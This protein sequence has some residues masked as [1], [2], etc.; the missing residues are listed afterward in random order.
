MLLYGKRVLSLSSGTRV[1][2]F[3]ILS[4]IGSGGMGEVYRARDTRLNRDVALKILP[5]AVAVDPHRL[6]RF[7]RE[8]QVLAALNH[9]HIAA[10]YGFEEG[11]GIDALVMELVGGP[12]LADRIERGPIPIEDALPI[13]RQL[14]EALDAAHEQ[15]IIHRDLKPENIKLTPDGTV[16]VLDF[17]LAKA[18][19]RTSVLSELAQSPT[20]MTPVSTVEGVICGTVAYMSPEQARGRPVDKRTDIW[21]FGCVLFEMLAGRKPF[22]GGSLPDTVA[23]ILTSEPDWRVLPPET[24]PRVRLLIE[25][26]FRKDPTQRLRDIGDVWFQ[27]EDTPNDFLSTDAARQRTRTRR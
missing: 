8:A 4:L 1:G 12:T 22:P 3:Q 23:A 17:G 6:A 25:R 14:A 16:K 18:V 26:C 5:E 15:G 19:E 11:N 10:I 13:A 7:K 24:P 9:P 20:V 21:A 27:L 2:G